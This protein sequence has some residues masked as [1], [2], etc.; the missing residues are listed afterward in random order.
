MNA[1][2]GGNVRPSASSDSIV[3]DICDSVG[4]RRMRNF[5]ATR[6]CTTAV[7]GGPA[8][9]SAQRARNTS[10]RCA[11]SPAGSSERGGLGDA[12]A[13]PQRLEVADV[14]ALR[15]TRARASATSSSMP[16]VAQPLRLRGVAAPSEKPGRGARRAPGTRAGRRR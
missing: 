6:R 4:H 8:A 14:R 13:V 11:P 1:A 2:G 7:D 12:A 9:S 10:T 16:S 5:G 3:S 15:P